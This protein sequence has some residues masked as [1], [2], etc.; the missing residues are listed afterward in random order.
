MF[1]SVDVRTR[2][3]FLVATAAAILGIL[4]FSVLEGLILSQRATSRAVTLILSGLMASAIFTLLWFAYHHFLHAL[5]RPK[6]DGRWFFY[7]PGFT[8]FVNIRQTAGRVSGTI[9]SDLGTPYGFTGR[10]VAGTLILT[11]VSHEKQRDL[12]GTIVLA[13]KAHGFWLGFSLVGHEG[14]KVALLPYIMTKDPIPDQN[15]LM[16]R[17]ESLLREQFLLNALFINE[18]EVLESQGELLWK[19]VT[20]AEQICKRF[21]SIS[22]ELRSRYNDRP[23]LDITDEYDVQDLMRALL[24]VF[25]DDIRPE[26]WTPSYA[27]GSSRMDFL[28]RDK[29]IVIET[30]KT[31]ASLGAKEVA[32]QLIIDMERYRAHPSCKTL[33]C[34][35]YDPEGRIANPEA[36]ERELSRQQDDF[37]VKVF[38]TPK[39]Y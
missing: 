5:F 23:A 38:V 30:K 21:H 17:F 6:V 22:K 37:A 1:N 28:L 8:E 16:Q 4:T 14:G 2:R 3:V 36:L 11:W 18:L 20:K 33:L 27:G 26:E 24:R 34:L 15:Y 9:T 19:D 13:Q 31:R 35:V 7:Y 25:F 29:S 32:D 10:I 39:V 12:S